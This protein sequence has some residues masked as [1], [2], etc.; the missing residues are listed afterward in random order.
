MERVY[1]NLKKN[2]PT[3]EV[4]YG[5]WSGP[6]GLARVQGGVNYYVGT[7][8]NSRSGKVDKIMEIF[9]Y[10]MSEEGEKLLTKGVEGTHYNVGANGEIQPIMD[11]EGID[12]LLS[13]YKH[14]LR[15]WIRGTAVFD[16]F[17]ATQCFPMMLRHVTIPM[18]E[19]ILICLMLILPSRLMETLDVRQVCAKCFFKVMTVLYIC[20]LPFPMLGEK[21]K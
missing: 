18:E 7:A 21:A 6:A 16:E 3:A 8:V 14:S 5:V 15:S 20:F 9:E 11:A 13:P 2:D 1:E 17:V 12:Y 4:S 19:L 10:L